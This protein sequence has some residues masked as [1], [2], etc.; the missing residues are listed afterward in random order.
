MILL[1]P[2]AL[3]KKIIDRSIYLKVGESKVI[4]LVLYIDDIFIATNYLSLL[5]EIKK[6]LP[7]N[8]ETKDMG[9]T[10]YVIGVEVFMIEI[11]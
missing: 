2:L 4:V 7:N 10:S 1:W 9:K 6:F 5:Y 11:T 3:R 8:F